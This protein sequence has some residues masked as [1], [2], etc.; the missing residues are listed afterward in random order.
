MNSRSIVGR[1]DTD[2]A[3]FVRNNMPIVLAMGFILLL[4]ILYLAFKKK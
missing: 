2:T 3:M 4:I 1:T